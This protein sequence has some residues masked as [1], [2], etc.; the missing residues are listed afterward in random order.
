MKERDGLLIDYVRTLKE[1]NMEEAFEIYLLLISSGCKQAIIAW[2]ERGIIITEE[3][4]EAYGPPP[5]L[6]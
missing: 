1:G 5:V 2:A 4:S 3:E 6:D